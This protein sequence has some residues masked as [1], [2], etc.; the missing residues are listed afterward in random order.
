MIKAF[1]KIF[2]LGQKYIQ[3]IFE[4]EAEVTEKID[5]SQWAFGKIDGQLYCRSKGKIQEIDCPD[6][7][8]NQAI[9]VV[10]KLEPKLPNNIIFYGEYLKK[11]KHNTL[12][13]ERIPK[14]HIILFGACKSDG[15]FLENY[16]DYAKMLGLESVPIIYR[17]KIDNFE[18]LKVLLQTTSILGKSKIEGVVVKN[19][20]KDLMLG[21]HVIPIMCGKFVSEEFKEVHQKNWAKENTGKGRWDIFKDSFQTEARWLKA[22]FYLRDSGE[23]ENSPRD[24]GKLMKRVNIDIEEEEKNKIQEFLWKEFGKDLLR[25][26]TRGLPQFYKDYLAKQNFE[27]EEVNENNNSL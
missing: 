10:K 14:N 7:L 15:T 4:D 20:N 9:E 27:G 23:L 16:D 3:N 21:G 12:S 19:Y 8:F 26:A 22:I 1:P 6:K 25:H 5:G 18:K 17:G 11:P 24:I 13:Y 2:T